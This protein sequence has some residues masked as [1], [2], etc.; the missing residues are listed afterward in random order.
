[1]S[2][3]LVLTHRYMDGEGHAEQWDYG[4]PVE[5][6]REVGENR[7]IHKGGNSEEVK[8]TSED[9]ILPAMQER[10]RETDEIKR[11]LEKDSHF[12]GFEWCSAVSGRE[13]GAFP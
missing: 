13:R 1:M 2:L 8:I 4:K 10:R 6:V 9:I 12:M 3:P 5:E 11:L 7:T